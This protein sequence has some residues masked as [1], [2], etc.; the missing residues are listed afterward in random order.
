M[1]HSATEDFAETLKLL[2][3]NYFRF[4]FHVNCSQSRQV[5]PCLATAVCLEIWNSIKGHFYNKTG[6]IWSGLF[7]TSH[8]NH[9]FICH[10]EWTDVFDN[11]INVLSHI[12]Y[13]L[14]LQTMSD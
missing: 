7:V 12:D 1:I 9:R 3:E 14:K 8:F 5:W 13:Q 4:I 2:F 10:K 11:D 6:E